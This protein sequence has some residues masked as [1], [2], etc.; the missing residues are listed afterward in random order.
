MINNQFSAKILQYLESN[1]KRLDETLLDE[2]AKRV[3][4]SFKRQLMQNRDNAPGKL[5]MSSGGKCV[6]QQW[7]TYKGQEGEPLSGRTANT[8][9][10]GDLLE[11]GISILGRLAGWQLLGKPDG[12]EQIVL[13]GVNGH[14]DDLL[15]IP[16]SGEYLIV[17]YKTMSEYSYR[18]F[19]TDGMDDMF[20]YLT[21]ASLYCEAMNLKRFVLVGICKNTGHICDQVI[22][23]RDDLIQKAKE[24]WTI[25]KTY[26]RCPDREHTPEPEKVYNRKTKEYDQT[27]RSILGIVCSYC[28][29]KFHCWPNIQTEIKSSKPIFLVC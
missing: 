21:Q 12:E 6:R 1:D 16:E 22:D 19:E 11:V 18:K 3:K 7:Y 24:R 28:Q 15:Y 13:D 20:G 5:R 17:E 27:G 4:V 9:L 10:T 14:F 26:D 29:F 8:F 2:A 25:I 23:K